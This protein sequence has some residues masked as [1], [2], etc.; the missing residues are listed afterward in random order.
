VAGPADAGRAGA[1]RRRLECSA[2]AVAAAA[3]DGIRGDVPRADRSSHHPL[4]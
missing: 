3:V 4:L 2:R 1:R